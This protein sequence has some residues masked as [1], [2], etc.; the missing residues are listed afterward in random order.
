MEKLRIAAVSYL[1]ARPLIAGLEDNPAVQLVREAPSTLMQMLE[2]NQADIA[3]V[4]VIDVLRADLKLHISPYYCIACQGQAMTVKIF[5]PVPIEQITNLAVDSQSH[6]S[7]A[8]ARILIN[9]SAFFCLAF[10]T[11]P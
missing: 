6:T 4:P 8:L 9:K 10:S 2:D 5:S 11:L 3:L 1:N 7:V